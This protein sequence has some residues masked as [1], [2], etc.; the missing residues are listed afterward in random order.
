[1]VTEHHRTIIITADLHDVTGSITVDLGSLAPHIAWTILRAAADDLEAY[2]PA[3]T[4]I[5]EG[6]PLWG[7]AAQ[8]D[9]G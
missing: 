9:E 6:E 5:H 2:E 4:V 1:V 7:Y 3:V 8:E